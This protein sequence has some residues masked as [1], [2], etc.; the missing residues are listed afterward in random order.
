MVARLYALVFLT[1]ILRACLAFLVLRFNAFCDHYKSSVSE[2]FWKSAY[3]L[4]TFSVGF[5]RFLWAKSGLKQGG[6]AGLSAFKRLWKRPEKLPPLSSFSLDLKNPLKDISFFPGERREKRV[7]DK[8]AE[9]TGPD[10]NLEGINWKLPPLDMLSAPPESAFRVNDR[11]HQKD[12]RRLLEKL[13][14][15]SISG[16]ISH[17]RSGRSSLYLSLSRKIM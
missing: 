2:L 5:S 17:I 13:Q 10:Q 14:Q 4:K 9:K 11:E 6:K 3:F 8:K 15:F 7:F 16:R 12:A 1:C